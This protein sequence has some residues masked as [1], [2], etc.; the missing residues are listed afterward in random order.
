MPEEK[1]SLGRKTTIYIKHPHQHK[2]NWYKLAMT[3][4]RQKTDDKFLNIRA[5][6][7]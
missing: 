5:N 6:R 7:F 2:T 3:T 4:F 1:E